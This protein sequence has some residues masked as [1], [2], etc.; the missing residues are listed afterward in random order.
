MAT[1]ATLAE[2][3]PDV[4]VEIML[5]VSEPPHTFA[6]RPAALA[7]RALAAVSRR[8][9]LWERLSALSFGGGG[10][11]ADARARFRA[12][13]A[14][15]R[16]ELER[17]T[18]SVRVLGSPER[19]VRCAAFADAEQQLAAA[20]GAAGRGA[21]LSLIELAM[22]SEEVIAAVALMRV[23]LSGSELGPAEV[24]R[25]CVDARATVPDA[26]LK[27]RWWSLGGRDLR[28]YRCRD[29]LHSAE[30]T[31]LELADASH[32]DTRR[33]WD[34][35][36]RGEVHEVHKVTLEALAAQPQP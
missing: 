36:R 29:H 8:A 9:D 10:C 21:Q 16:L 32:A 18:A 3:P 23:I 28:G 1:A 7:C 13:R 33:F 22:R 5:K 15:A 4:L 14:A 24:E 6:L 17:A 35:L 20:F 27:L 2:L 30:R 25:A 11:G 31:L 19:S 26:T 12:A 34:V